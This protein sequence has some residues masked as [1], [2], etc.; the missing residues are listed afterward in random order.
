MHIFFV[1]IVVCVRLNRRPPRLGVATYWAVWK[2]DSHPYS[3]TDVLPIVFNPVW[4]VICNANG[5]PIWCGGRNIATV[6]K[7]CGFD[8]GSLKTPMCKLGV[9]SISDNLVYIKKRL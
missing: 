1:P 7:G 3:L 6:S 2:I 5:R 8:L 4:S 9:F